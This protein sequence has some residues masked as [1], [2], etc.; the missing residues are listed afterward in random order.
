MYKNNIIN[1]L[2]LK[3]HSSLR[4]ENM[5]RGGRRN[6]FWQTH[7]VTSAE[8]KM[9]ECQHSQISGGQRLTQFEGWLSGRW[10]QVWRQIYF[11]SVLTFS[12]T[13]A[14]KHFSAALVRRSDATKYLSW[15]FFSPAVRLQYSQIYRTL[16]PITPPR[17]RIYLHSCFEASG[18]HSCISSVSLL[19][20]T[21]YI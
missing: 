12:V 18:E 8:L 19:P 11:R 17:C 1:Q 10:R 9:S 15:V 2:L 4:S 16:S 5:G 13:S 21:V 3:W 6:F 14:F 20:A 7:E